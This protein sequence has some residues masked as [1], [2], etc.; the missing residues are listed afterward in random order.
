MKCNT[1][2]ADEV[3]VC[4]ICDAVQTRPFGTEYDNVE[5]RLNSTPSVLYGSEATGNNTNDSSTGNSEFVG[6]VN[7]EIDRLMKRAEE[8]FKSGKAWLGAKNR[9]RARRE[10]QRAF[11]YYENILK[12]DPDFGPAKEA[13]AKCL[14]KMA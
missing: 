8:R 6:D 4:P 11:K 3:R 2:L 9:P 1:M 10:F 7:E 5:S 13:R 14:L 12:L